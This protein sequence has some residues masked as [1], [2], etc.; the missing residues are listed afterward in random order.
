[1]LLATVITQI[2]GMAILS[3]AFNIQWQWGQ[4]PARLW[5]CEVY[6]PHWTQHTTLIPNDRRGD[7]HGSSTGRNRTAPVKWRL[8]CCLQN[9]VKSNE[10]AI[11]SYQQEQ[12]QNARMLVQICGSR[13]G[14]AIMVDTWRCKNNKG[15]QNNYSQCHPDLCLWIDEKGLPFVHLVHSIGEHF[16]LWAAPEWQGKELEFLEDRISHT[17]PFPVFIKLQTDWRWL[18]KV[19]VFNAI[20]ISGKQKVST[21]CGTP[22]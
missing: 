13:L 19:V 16:T 20:Q 18:T 22:W 7:R 14:V 2:E 4:C 15:F 17:L 21:N 5:V 6:W 10:G 11:Q 9:L 8:Q 3:L 12:R 1:M